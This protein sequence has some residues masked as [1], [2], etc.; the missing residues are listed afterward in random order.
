LAYDFFRILRFPL[1]AFDGDTVHVR[2]PK[3]INGEERITRT[4]LAG[5][6]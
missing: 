6:L 5:L 1:E 2:G 3:V 4:P